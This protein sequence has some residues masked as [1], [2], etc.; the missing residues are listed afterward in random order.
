MSAL[1]TPK[2]VTTAA[3]PDRRTLSGLMSRCTT[4]L[5]VRVRERARDVAQDAHRLGDR[6][7]AVAREPRRGAT[8]LRRT[9]S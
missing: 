7:L 6:Q 8:R 2:S 3:P 4:P 1:A 9:A 5:L